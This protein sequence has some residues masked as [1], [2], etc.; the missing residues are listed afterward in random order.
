V[1]V[2][3]GL[4]GVA[5]AFVY[6]SLYEGFGLP[7]LEA[8]AR[9]VPVACADC[10]SLP[11]VAGDAALLFDPCS[12][13]A[14]AQAIE[15]LLGDPSLAASLRERGIARVRQFSWERTARLTLDSY[16]RALGSRS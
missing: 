14:I 1:G 6:P 8:M 7:V 13:D 10:S 5:D 3:V 12:Q 11:E 16:A 2:V 4:W 9:G 15:R